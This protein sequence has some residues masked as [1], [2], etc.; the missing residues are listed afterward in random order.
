MSNETDIGAD[1][2]LASEGRGRITLLAGVVAAIIAAA[3]L[4]AF[5]SAFFI[6]LTYALDDN[7]LYA[8]N[9][10]IM[11]IMW[12]IFFMALMTAGCHLIRSG[13]ARR[14]YNIIPGV[15]LYFAGLALLVNAFYFFV[16]SNFAY[17]VLAGIFGIVLIVAEWGSETT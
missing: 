15:S 4:I 16:H 17:G 6:T 11:S 13:M 12:V 1:V 9:D 14:L 3:G 8:R 5:G 2:E 10:L 7:V